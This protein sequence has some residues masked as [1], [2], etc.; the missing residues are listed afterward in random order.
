MK[1]R[2]YSHRIWEFYGASF[3]IHSRNSIR[4]GPFI[5]AFF[6]KFVCFYI[7]GVNP[8]LIAYFITWGVGFASVRLIFISAIRI[9]GKNFHLSKNSIESVGYI[10]C[11]HKFPFLLWGFVG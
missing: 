7:F 2:K 8:D 4:A 5:I 6:Y 11:L 9:L 10:V 1:N 3:R